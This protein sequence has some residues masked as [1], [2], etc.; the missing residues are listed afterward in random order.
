MIPNHYATTST[1]AASSSSA[2][3]VSVAPVTSALSGIVTSGLTATLSAPSTPST[4]VAGASGGFSKPETFSTSTSTTQSS[5]ISTT[6]QPGSTNSSSNNVLAGLPP[7]SAS[8]PLPLPSGPTVFTITSLHSSALRLIERIYFIHSHD[9]MFDSE[10]C[11]K[12]DLIGLN[13]PNYSDRDRDLYNDELLAPFIP[14]QQQQQGGLSGRSGISSSTTSG[15]IS[16]KP[17]NTKGAV[18]TPS[19][20]KTMFRNKSGDEETNPNLLTSGSNTPT[21]GSS[22]N[23]IGIGAVEKTSTNTNLATQSNEVIEGRTHRADSN[24]STRGYFGLFDSAP[25][26]APPLPGPTGSIQSILTNMKGR[27]DRP[28]NK[29]ID[30]QYVHVLGIATVRVAAHGFLWFSSS[31]TKISDM[32]MSIEDKTAISMKA[33]HQLELHCEVV[34]DIYEILLDAIDNT[35]KHAFIREI[36]FDLVDEIET[37]KTTYQISNANSQAPSQNHS[38][39]SSPTHS[40]YPRTGSGREGWTTPKSPP[41]GVIDH[42]NGSSPSPYISG[43]HSPQRSTS[44]RHQGVGTAEAGINLEG[45]SHSASFSARNSPTRTTGKMTSSS[46]LPPNLDLDLELIHSASMKDNSGFS[47]SNP[48]GILSSK[49]SPTSSGK[50]TAAT[51]TAQLPE[52]NLVS[53]APVKAYQQSPV[54]TTNPLKLKRGKNLIESSSSSSDDESSHHS[55]TPVQLLYSSKDSREGSTKSGLSNPHSSSGRNSRSTTLSPSLTPGV[56]PTAAAAHPPNFQ[57]PSLP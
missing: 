17:G 34:N 3:P 11:T 21:S 8:V 4:G 10:E 29:R 31:T 18:G 27:K 39:T 51:A 48:M 2:N 55:G 7:L 19:L 30:R 9:W 25:N 5:T 22:S 32:N 26:A 23:L 43:P 1:S 12:W 36:L 54:P 53:P 44:F 38:N 37:R 15:S 41:I 16:S 42:S 52:S 20:Q 35:F 50:R 33:M 45:Q 49:V 28:E 56:T 47:F 40:F 46:A 14:Q 6:N 13:I 57:P 24:V